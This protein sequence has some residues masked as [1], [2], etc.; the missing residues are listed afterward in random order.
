MKNALATIQ[1]NVITL[2]R[3]N[4]TVPQRRILFAIIETISPYLRNDLELQKGREISYQLGVFDISKIVY[5]ASDLCRPELYGELRTALNQ[6]KS[7][8][9]FLETEDMSFGSS[10]VLKYK[11]DVR[12]EYVELAI[13]EELFKMCIDLS[14]GYTLYQTKVALSFTSSYA[15]KIYELLAKWR[16]QSKFYISIEELRRLTDTHTKYL[17]IAQLK[18]RVLDTAKEQ[19]DQSDITDLRFKYKDKRDGKRIVGFDI[20][21]IKT[22][23]SH[24]YEKQITANAPSLRWDFKKS[25]IDNFAIYGIVVKGETAN[26]IKAYQGKFGEHKLAQDLES[27]AKLAE[28]NKARSIPAYI[29]SCFKKG[30]NP[31]AAPGVTPQGKAIAPAGVHQ[32]YEKEPWEMTKEERVAHAMKKRAESDSDAGLKTIADLFGNLKK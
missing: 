31:S 24:E 5:K 32:N 22:D 12:A 30:M 11:F 20:I 23:Q 18:K 3:S 2:S 6:L 9:Y 14:K 27:F 29:M 1:S 4:F 25:L 16:N 8:N 7:K 19:L 10:L 28:K 15:M 17:M 13:D 26:T 21:V